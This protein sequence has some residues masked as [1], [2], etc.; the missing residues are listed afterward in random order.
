MKKKR[1]EIMKR[2]LRRLSAS[3]L[4]L[5]LGLAVTGCGS[6]SPSSSKVDTSANEETSGTTEKK[7]EEQS[8][9]DKITLGYWESPN[10][11]L[12]A[13]EK[14]ELEKLYPDIK[15]EWVEF[16]SGT[17]ILTA[18]QSGSLDFATIGTPPVTMGIVNNY[19]FKV[20]YLHDIIGES[21][22]LI[23]KKDSGITSVEDIKGKTIAVPFGTT[24]HFAFQNVLKHYNIETTD[25][26]LLDMKGPDI[27]A[28]WQRGDIDG[29]YI[30]ESIKSQL[31]EDDGTQIISSAEAAEIG[32]LTA[33]VGIVHNDFYAKYPE[34]VKA[35]IDVIDSSV[36]EY[37]EDPDGSAK[38]MAAGLGLSEEDT[39]IAMNE[40][41]VKDKS[42][43]AEYFKDGGELQ[44][45]LKETGDF[46]FEQKS[47]SNQPDQ[48]VINAAI[49]T[50][51]YENR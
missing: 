3:L 34:I 30:W 50:E 38:L 31:I 9:P 13:K 18:M 15:I 2:I 35:Y 43:Q 25:F 46:L 8:L 1:R 5:T 40:I 27:F 36:K 16:Q 26:T 7:D 19:P 12:L 41:I 51:L 22:G 11:E 48:S 17:D 21:E 42:E 4:A 44:T 28:A 37:R 6:A 23:A 20:F 14:G 49:L 47:L 10:G 32:G 33:E 45:T 24:S 39:K 29:A